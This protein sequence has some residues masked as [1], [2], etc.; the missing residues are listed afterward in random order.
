MNDLHSTHRH[1]DLRRR[2]REEHEA[3]ELRAET[4][5]DVRQVQTAELELRT[6][7]ARM[8]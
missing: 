8:R 6:R 7:L 4:A 1:K 2:F 5:R 3:N